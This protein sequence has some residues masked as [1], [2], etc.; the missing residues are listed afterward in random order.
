MLMTMTSFELAAERSRA[1]HIAVAQRLAGDPAVL[2]QA[3]ARVRRWL[4]DG[5]VARSYAQAWQEL[6]E[7]PLADVLAALAERSERMHELRQVSPFA[8]ALDA[9][10]RWRIHRQVREQLSDEARGA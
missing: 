6:L 2:E 1:L 4:D 5:S 7:R 8:G 9:R 10:T 3:R